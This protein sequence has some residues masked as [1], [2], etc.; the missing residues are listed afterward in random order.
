MLGSRFFSMTKLMTAFRT[1]MERTP[2]GAS[3]THLFGPCGPA[4][5]SG[6]IIAVV[7]DAVKRMLITGSRSHV[8][9]EGAKIVLPSITDGNAPAAVM[10]K[11]FVVFVSA[12]R[13]HLGPRSIFRAIQG[14]IAI[15]IAAS[16]VA[17][18]E[19]S[20]TSQIAFQAPTGLRVLSLSVQSL[21]REHKFCA[22]RATTPPVQVR[23]FVF[24][25]LF[26]QGETAKN[27]S[28][29]SLGYHSLND[30]TSMGDI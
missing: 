28:G 7:V 29:E 30:T 17:V 3:I 5:V 10:F 27:F 2:I 22:A 19:K 14:A 4:A 12:S 20:L 16:C 18:T 25:N 8:S 26:D 13:F 21:G 11:G 15:A 23:L 9:E 6:F 24:A 1:G